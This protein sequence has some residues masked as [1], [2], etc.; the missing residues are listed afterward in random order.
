[1]IN[2]AGL[3][4]T[5]FDVSI[6]VWP[7]LNTATLL[8]YNRIGGNIQ[9]GIIGAP[10]SI[11]NIGVYIKSSSTPNFDYSVA[12]A[13]S[14]QM[15]PSYLEGQGRLVG[16]GLE[17]INTTAELYR[18]GSV[19][20]YRVVGNSREAEGI[21]FYPPLPGSQVIQGTRNLVWV[22]TPP[23]NTSTAMLIPGT[24]QWGAEEGAYLPVAF[25]GD[26]PPV[27]PSANGIFFDPLGTETL[28][29]AAP[30]SDV[31]SIPWGQLG[32]LLKIAPTSNSGI[33]FSGLDEHS[34]IQ[35]Q[36]V[37]YY[38]YFP[39]Q[40]SDLITLARPSC[41]YDPKALELYTEVLTRLPIVVPASW[42]ASGDWFWDVVT[43]VKDYAPQIG[44]MIGGVPGMAIGEAAS[45]LAD[46]GQKRYGP[47]SDYIAPPGNTHPKRPQAKKPQP[48][49]GP[50]P[51]V[52]QLSKKERQAVMLARKGSSK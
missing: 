1:M 5:A 16:C 33:M 39:S 45:T 52:F 21:M 29:G 30:Q 13:F 15:P 34:T 23:L 10:V 14:L 2:S 40:N 12:P 8:K 32:P 38:E 19:L 43:A 7:W 44:S 37:W 4:G 47:K 18:S 25:Q 6:V 49:P 27:Q 41:Q 31:M 17:A 46:W 26:N 20:G 42:N 22:P 51:A 11:P 48:K 3:L 35:L 24:R 36:T 50:K 28:V 9:R